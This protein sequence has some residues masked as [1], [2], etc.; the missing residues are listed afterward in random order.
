M[1]YLINAG[2][3]EPRTKFGVGTCSV[4]NSLLLP[5][6]SLCVVLLLSTVEWRVSES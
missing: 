1:R 6:E 2:I 3:P 4:S 5:S